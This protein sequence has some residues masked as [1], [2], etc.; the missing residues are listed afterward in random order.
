MSVSTTGANQEGRRGSTLGVAAEKEAFFA[1]VSMFRARAQH[2]R[3]IASRCVS[4]D[5]WKLPRRARSALLKLL[6]L[7]CV[8][9][10]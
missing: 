5:A 7:C 8:L 2:S 6:G 9:P 3:G 4:L 10:D 1:C